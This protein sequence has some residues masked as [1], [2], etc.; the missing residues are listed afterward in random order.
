MAAK[1]EKLQK[2][3]ITFKVTATVEVKF[4]SYDNEDLNKTAKEQISIWVEE[5]LKEEDQ[6]P[7]FVDTQS[8][9]ESIS[10]TVKVEAN[11]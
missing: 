4:E 1:K 9:E 5:T 7:L 3:F 10:K 6:V 2:E 8:G 11:G